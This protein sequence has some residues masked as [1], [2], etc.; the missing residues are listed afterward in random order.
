MTGDRNIWSGFCW[1]VDY[2]FFWRNYLGGV[3]R[4]VE[5]SICVELIKLYNLRIKSVD[6]TFYNI[7]RNN[8]IQYITRE[9]Y[10]NVCRDIIIL[11]I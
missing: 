2:E 11:Y 9:S 5:Y 7:I 3:D 6:C 4:F 8:F 10:M 1:I